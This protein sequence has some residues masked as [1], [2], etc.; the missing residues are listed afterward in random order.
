VLASLVSDNASHMLQATPVVQVGQTV[1][2]LLQASPPKTEKGSGLWIKTKKQAQTSLA[3][4]EIDVPENNDIAQMYEFI[5][6]KDLQLVDDQ[7]P[8]LTVGF[9]V[10]LIH[11]YNILQTPME[12]WLQ[13]WSIYLN[14]L[15]EMEGHPQITKCSLCTKGPAHIK[16]S[17]CFGT[18][19]FCNDCCLRHHLHLPFHCLLKWNGKHYDPTLLY[20]LGFILF[21]G[22]GGH[23]C[24]KTVEVCVSQ[25]F[26]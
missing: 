18:N 12:K 13:Q 10:L 24:P 11:T 8:N 20:L 5:G 21:L 15:L 19:I 2:E 1:S 6:D 4:E 9:Y 14:I 23:P 17:D 26:V 16:C 7:H 25:I 22:H 3:E